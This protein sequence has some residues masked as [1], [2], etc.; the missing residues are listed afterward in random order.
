MKKQLI[1]FLEELRNSDESR[2]RRWAGI[3]TA[4]TAVFVVMLWMF[5]L[6]ANVKPLLSNTQE[7]RNHSTFLQVMKKGSLVLWQR[8]LAFIEKRREIEIKP[9]MPT[10]NPPNLEPTPLREFP[11]VN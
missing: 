8:F 2:K 11:S 4:A 3:L 7:E 10:F 1:S 6:N 5:L 9:Q